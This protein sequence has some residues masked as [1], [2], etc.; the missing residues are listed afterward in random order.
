MFTQTRQLYIIIF[1]ILKESYT[2][3]QASYAGWLGAYPPSSCL[4]FLHQ[5]RASSATCDTAGVSV[6]A[7]RLRGSRSVRT[8]QGQSLLESGARVPGVP[9][10]R[11]YWQASITN[12]IKIQCAYECGDP[13]GATDR[14]ALSPRG[15]FLR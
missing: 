4:Q 1:T 8:P 13:E 15:P 10:S 12:F 11:S 2:S 14:W 6:W 3:L 7:C 9:T 5:G